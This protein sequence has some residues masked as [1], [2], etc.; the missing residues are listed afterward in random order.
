MELPFFQVDAFTTQL[1]A[2]NPA[3]VVLDAELLDEVGMRSIA[4]E[5]ARSSP[6]QRVVRRGPFFYSPCIGHPPEHR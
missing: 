4:R 1:F 6:P 5:R 2:G 3:G